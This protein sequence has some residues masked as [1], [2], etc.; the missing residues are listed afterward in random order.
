VSGACQLLANRIGADNAR[1][2]VAARDSQLMVDA[3]NQRCEQIL[4]N[5]LQ[6][7]LDATT[8]RP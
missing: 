2:E 6:T 3:D 1:V 8:G 7:A 5:L 4:V